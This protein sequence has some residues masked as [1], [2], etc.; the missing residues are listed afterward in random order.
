MDVSLPGRLDRYFTAQNAHDFDTLVDCFTTDARVRDE[1]EDIVGP[2]AIRAWKERTSAKYNVNVEPLTCHPQNG[3]SV[4]VARVS[5][6]FPGSPANLTYRF[7]LAVDGR[8]S[9]LE[10]G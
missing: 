3:R 5:G 8:I 1:G 4:V 9:A 10:I 6:S 2:E 7:H